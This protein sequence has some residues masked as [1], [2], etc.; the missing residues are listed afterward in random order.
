MAALPGVPGGG[1]PR[2]ASQ[3]CSL[4]HVHAYRTEPAGL[5]QDRRRGN[6]PL[7]AL[8]P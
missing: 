5:L 4:S 6:F 7:Q 1:Q 8:R 2:A 3:S